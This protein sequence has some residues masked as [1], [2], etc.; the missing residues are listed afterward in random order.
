MMAKSQ[1]ANALRYIASAPEGYDSSRGIGYI[2][3]D[4][5]LLILPYVGVV[6]GG[7][8]PGMLN[9]ARDTLRKSVADLVGGTYQSEEGYDKQE[10][11]PEYVEG[12]D[13]L[14]SYQT[15][16]FDDRSEPNYDS[17]YMDQA[18]TAYGDAEDLEVEAPS[19]KVQ[20]SKKQKTSLEVIAEQSDK[21][22]NGEQGDGAAG[23]EQND[24]LQP[25]KDPA[26][27]LAQANAESS[28]D[29]SQYKLD[30]GMNNYPAEN[31]MAF[32]EALD[33]TLDDSMRQGLSL[34]LGGDPAKQFG[35]AIQLGRG[36][37]VALPSFSQ[38]YANQGCGSQCYN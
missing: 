36:S 27:L 21:G 5:A 37:I 16:G 12:K 31:P 30:R 11:S 19:D 33:P 29:D 2:N 24:T 22:Y 38:N 10:P 35:Q 14:T 6:M 15:E 23:T 9:R 18:Y 25:Y 28:V 32:A 3:G 17:L 20:K 26:D 34:F 8:G 7:D 1:V 4:S 13:R